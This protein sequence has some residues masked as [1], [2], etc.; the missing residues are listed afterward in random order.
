MEY[1]FIANGFSKN[2]AISKIDDKDIQGTEQFSPETYYQTRL[3]KVNILN[4]MAFSKKIIKKF[5]IVIGHRK[6]LICICD[7]YKERHQKKPMVK[8]TAPKTDYKSQTKTQS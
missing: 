7:F 6:V 2:F 1:I 4:I 8:L 3:T 5:Q